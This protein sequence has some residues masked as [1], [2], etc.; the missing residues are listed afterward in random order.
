MIS[1]ISPAKSLDFSPTE[2]DIIC[3]IPEFRSD[4]KKL[5]NHLKLLSVDDI[6]SLMH[7]SN[8]LSL[9]NYNRFKK[10]R[11]KHDESNSKAAILAFNGDVYRG[12]EANNWD[13]NFLE[14]SN[15][16]V[17]I[18][19]GLYGLLRPLDYIQPYRLEMGTSLQNDR[20]KNLYQFWG[21]KIAKAINKQIKKTN[22]KY[23]LNAASKEYF[24]SVNKNLIKVPIIDV[25]FKE[26]RNGDLKFIS[27]S[28]KKA[29]GLITKY[30]IQ[31]NITDVE[32]LKGFNYEGYSFHSSNANELLFVK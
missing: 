25:T 24:K 2:R 5:I 4:A 28:A 19:S 3:S 30:M 14:T 9:L 27:F 22:S 21:D 17:R 16:K 23:L 8:D 13:N 6:K 18:L 26:F 20:G 1:I 7:I 12:L 31:E 10:F 29:R 15:E 11:L 32:M